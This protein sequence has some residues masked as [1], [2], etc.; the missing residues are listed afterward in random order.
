MSRLP[1]LVTLGQLPSPDARELGNHT[2]RVYRNPVEYIVV[3]VTSYFR[4]SCPVVR[5]E[6]ICESL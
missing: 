2:I 5:A 3:L 6:V 1:R 4:Y